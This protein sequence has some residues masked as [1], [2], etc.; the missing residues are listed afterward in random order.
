MQLKNSRKEQLAPCDRRYRG[1]SALCGLFLNEERASVP[2]T[3]AALRRRNVFIFKFRFGAALVVN[4]MAGILLLLI[5]GLAALALVVMPVMAVMDL[6]VF[7]TAARVVFLVVRRV[8]VFLTEFERA[9]VLMPVLEA[10]RRALVVGRFRVVRL[11]ALFFRGVFRVAFR[12]DF[13]GIS[14]FLPGAGRDPTTSAEQKKMKAAARTVALQDGP[15][16]PASMPE[17]RGVHRASS[18]ASGCMTICNK[19]VRFFL[20]FQEAQRPRATEVGFAECPFR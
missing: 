2:V 19:V 11:A 6:V 7:L 15:L 1:G 3:H 14:C 10:V 9:A 16:T 12:V 18:L 20:T 13:T 8:A 5:L 4:F 17:I